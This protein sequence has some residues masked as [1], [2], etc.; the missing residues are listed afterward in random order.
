[1]LNRTK[2]KSYETIACIQA[3]GRPE[4]G[5]EVWQFAPGPR[6]AGAPDWP[7]FIPDIIWQ[8]HACIL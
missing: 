3:Q 6:Y 5:G 7:R 4:G 2:F 8:V 1:M